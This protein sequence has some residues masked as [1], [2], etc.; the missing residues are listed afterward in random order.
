VLMALVRLRASLLIV[1][2]SGVGL[3]QTF[4]L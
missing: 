4:W 3:G 2:N 1:A